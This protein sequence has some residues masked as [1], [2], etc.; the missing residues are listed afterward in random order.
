MAKKALESSVSHPSDKIGK[1]LA[2]K[3]VDLIMKQLSKM[4]QGPTKKQ[5]R[6]QFNL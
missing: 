6:C 4:R 2:E 3:S 1:I 5:K